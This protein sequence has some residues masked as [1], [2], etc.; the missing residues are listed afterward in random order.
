M[1][2]ERAGVVARPNGVCRFGRGPPSSSVRLV[3]VRWSR[4]PLPASTQLPDWPSPGPAACPVTCLQPESVSVLRMRKHWD[5][6][7]RGAVFFR[8]VRALFISDVHLGT[9]SAQAEALLEFLKHL[10]ADVIY[11]VG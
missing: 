5:D 6:L 7:A 4:S 9:R 3:P 10:E 1:V 2:G 8:H 11:L